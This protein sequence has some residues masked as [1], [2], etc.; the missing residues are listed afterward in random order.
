[1]PSHLPRFCLPLLLAAS[2]TS[3]CAGVHGVSG[4]APQTLYES[5]IFSAD[6]GPPLTPAA[7]ARQLGDAD[8]IVVGEYHGHQGAHLLQSQLQ[9]AL[10]RQH[11]Q[12]V[13]AL[14]PFDLDHQPVV[15]DYL[16]GH[17]GEEELIEDAGAW[18]NYKASYRPLMEFA[19]RQ[20]LPVIAANAPAGVVRCVGRQGP[21]YLELLPPVRRSLLPEQPFPEVPG[22]R[23]KFFETMAGSGHG[24]VSDAGRERMDNAYHAQLLRDA[25]MADQVIRAQQ[26]YP[27][28]QILVITGTFHSEQRLGL[29]GVVEQREPELKV[30]VI[31]PVTLDNDAA[32]PAVEEHRAKGDYLYFLQPLPQQYRDDER[33]NAAMK[34]QFSQARELDCL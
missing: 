28:H 18:S 30:A 27:D 4:S 23:R 21:D 32:E 13:L 31:S 15:N 9:A 29:V 5:A 6:P 33:R 25:T 12:Q 8:V 20:Q 11:P 24:E 3:G 14:E 10:H 7:L 17:L 2:L 22:Y 16:A 26:Q 1:M 34:A 19:R